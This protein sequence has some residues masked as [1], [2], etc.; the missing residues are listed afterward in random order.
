MTHSYGA[1]L[2]RMFISLLPGNA[3]FFFLTQSRVT[4]GRCRIHVKYDSFVWSCLVCRAILRVCFCMCDM[5][6]SNVPWLMHMWHVGD[7]VRMLM[8]LCGTW[9]IYMRHD[10]V[11]WDM[12]HSCVTCARW[13][14]YADV[15]LWDT[16]HSYE[17]RLIHMRHDS[18]I[19]D[20]THSYETWLIHM[21]HV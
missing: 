3:A 1:W 20:M 12:T 15:S 4:Y 10:S 17:T 14:S 13:R 21:W 9:L 7:D 8:F 2:I 6:H 16:T 5:T 18:F 19:W 11:L